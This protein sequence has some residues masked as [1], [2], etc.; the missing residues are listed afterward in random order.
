MYK[1]SQ[2][3]WGLIAKL[4]HWVV[5]LLIIWQLFTGFNLSESEQFLPVTVDPKYYTDAKKTVGISQKKEIQIVN[6]GRLVD[7]KINL[8]IPVIQEMASYASENK[9]HLKFNVNFGVR[10]H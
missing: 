3:S 1:G 5:A 9:I 7:W 6:M 10:W 2:N 8:L 4:F